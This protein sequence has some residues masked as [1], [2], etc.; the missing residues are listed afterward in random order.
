MPSARALQPARVPAVR[1][2][3]AVEAVEYGRQLLL[4]RLALWQERPETADAEVGA[5][6]AQ[7]GSAL[8]LAARRLGKYVTTTWTDKVPTLHR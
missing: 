3:H 4:E 2:E 8:H 7:E 1:L 6:R 5:A